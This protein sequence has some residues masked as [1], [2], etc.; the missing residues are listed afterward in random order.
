MPNAAPFSFW[1]TTPIQ[2]LGRPLALASLWGFGSLL[3][4]SPAAI[5]QITQATITEILDG[6]AVF[7][8][9]G[10]N[11]ARVPATVDTIVEFQET[12]RTEE[13]RAALAF[14][15]GAVGRMAMNSQITVGQCIEVQQ[16]ILLAAGPAN[17]CTA[18]F[19]IG[20]QGTTYAI[21]LDEETGDQRIQVLEGVLDVELTDESSP[22]PERLQRVR[23]GEELTIDA[24]GRFGARRPL[25][26]DDIEMLLRNDV[27]EGFEG[28]LPGIEN[29][30]LTLTNLYG[31]ADIPCLPGFQRCTTPIRG[32]F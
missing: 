13:A 28:T 23:S 25:R 20:V 1:K 8:E 26:Q 24:D 12:V 14:D 9:T 21:V 11:D 32:L 16:G 2:L 3:L 4:V 22:E 30:E 29:L 5:A 31:G 15:N 19:S 18:T 27:F 10:V 7:V 17:G 6:D